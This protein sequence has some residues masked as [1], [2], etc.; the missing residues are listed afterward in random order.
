MNLCMACRTPSS[1]SNNELLLACNPFTPLSSQHPK[2]TSAHKLTCVFVVFISDYNQRLLAVQSPFIK[3]SRHP[4]SDSIPKRSTSAN[5]RPASAT[6]HSRSVTRPSSAHIIRSEGDSVITAFES[7]E[8]RKALSQ[9]SDI[10]TKGSAAASRIWSAGRRDYALTVPQVANKA[11]NCI[12]PSRVAPSL[13][14]LNI[15]LSREQDLEGLVGVGDGD[16]VNGARGRRRPMTAPS[17]RSSME[18]VAPAWMRA[19]A[20]PPAS[21]QADLEN[22]TEESFVHDDD[23]QGDLSTS[24]GFTVGIGDITNLAPLSVLQLE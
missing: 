1:R 3:V 18:T 6:S 5:S 15:F 10:S 17:R 21:Q 12:D 23:D 19:E 7:V 4:A 20:I 24:Q 11:T 22:V 14:V 13:G 16:Q 2:R 8:M 9:G